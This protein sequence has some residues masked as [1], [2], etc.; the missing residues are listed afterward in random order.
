MKRYKVNAS[1]A[2][3]LGFVTLLVVLFCLPLTI[4]QSLLQQALPSNWG[5]QTLSGHWWRG[6]AVVQL[7]NQL[8]SASLSWSKSHLL[9]P[10]EWSLAHPDASASGRFTV[11]FSQS[12]IWLDQGYI[13]PKLINRLI[14]AKQNVVLAGED[15]QLEQWQLNY[16]WQSQQWRQL[17][18]QAHWSNGLIKHRL[19]GYSTQTH[20]DHWYAEVTLEADRPQLVLNERLT[21]QPLLELMLRPDLEL[22]LTV[23]PSMLEALGQRWPGKPQY[24]AFVMVQPLAWD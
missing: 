24:P 19:N 4:W 3:L 17:M 10:F 1:L 14:P 18:G 2:S 21:Q 6:Q 16:D 8:S 11:S 23:M 7:S 15:I 12:T 22:E 5:L 13:R 20:V 9:E